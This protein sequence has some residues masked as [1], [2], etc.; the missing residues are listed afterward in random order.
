MEE[1]IAHQV[2]QVVINLAV[3]CE[4]VLKFVFESAYLWTHNHA[5]C[6]ICVSRLLGT[7]WVSSELL[8]KC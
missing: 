6:L 8:L 5:R 3:N 4:H 2:P 7:L 1:G